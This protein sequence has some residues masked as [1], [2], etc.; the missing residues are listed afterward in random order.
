LTHG[1]S[2]FKVHNSNKLGYLLTYGNNNT[3]WSNSN[4]GKA[5]KL[6]GK[7][8]N[9]NKIQKNKT[10][11][12]DNIVGKIIKNYKKNDLNCI[13]NVNLI[14]PVTS[15]NNIQDYFNN[16]YKAEYNSENITKKKYSKNSKR[17]NRNKE[18]DEKEGKIKIND[19][20]N[21]N[22]NTMMGT[23][24]DA[25]K[26]KNDKNILQK[27]CNYSPEEVHFYIISS[28]QNGNNMLNKN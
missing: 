12:A 11:K 20:Y 9:N 6:S 14:P 28:I 1:N 15:L 3:E 22:N 2:F 21:H 17:R 19:D 26:N 7:K 24:D 4:I 18:K 10:S 23:N 13:F 16:L 25:S 27:L 8:S 5:M